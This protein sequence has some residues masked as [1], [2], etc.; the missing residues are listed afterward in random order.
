M[1]LPSPCCCLSGTTRQSLPRRDPAAGVVVGQDLRTRASLF[2]QAAGS[3]LAETDT[4]PVSLTGEDKF[5]VG[6][7]QRE[8]EAPYF[9]QAEQLAELLCRDAAAGLAVG[10]LEH[11]QLSRFIEPH[12]THGAR[13][14]EAGG[15]ARQR[16]A[17]LFGGG[18]QGN[19][20][21]PVE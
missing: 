1:A 8:I 7:F 15:I 10:E 13:R 9:G 3:P 2:R 16:S 21:H 14:A 17:E 20:G 18:A 6:D 5:S 11:R 19:A 4:M 12:G